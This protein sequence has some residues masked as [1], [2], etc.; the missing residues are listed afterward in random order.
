MFIVPTC[1]VVARSYSSL[2]WLDVPSV[3][4]GSISFSTLRFVVKKI[5]EPGRYIG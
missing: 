1:A 2:N 3:P 5:F 4:I